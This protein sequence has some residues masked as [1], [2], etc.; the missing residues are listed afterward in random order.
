MKQ[1]I[2]IIFSFLFI[3]AD[4]E[5]VAAKNPAVER[6]ADFLQNIFML[7]NVDSLKAC[8]DTVKNDEAKLRLMAR[9]YFTT[10]ETHTPTFLAELRSLNSKG[11]LIDEGAINHYDN[12]VQFAHRNQFREAIAELKLV[13]DWFDKQMSISTVSD[14][15][16]EIRTIYNAAGLREERL[17]FYQQKLDYYLRNG[18]QENT[19]T[20]YHGIAGYYTLT[21]AY[22][23]AISNYMKAAEVAKKF[24]LIFYYN[25]IFCIGSYYYQ[26]GNK[27]LAR[28]Y[29][30]QVLSAPDKF[31]KGNRALVYYD[32]SEIS[33]EDGK[34]E[35]SINQLDSAEA[36]LFT[37]ETG[38]IGLLFVKEMIRL[39]KGM[40]FL[41]LD[42]DSVAKTYID[43][44]K[45][46]ADS[47]GLRLFTVNGYL[48]TDFALFSYF[49]KSGEKK[50][51]EYFLLNALSRAREQKVNALTLKYLRAAAEFYQTPGSGISSKYYDQYARLTDSLYE[52]EHGNNIAYYEAVLQQNTQNQR[53]D[54]LE[55]LRMI[56]EVKLGQ[57][58]KFLAAGSLALGLLFLLSVTLFLGYR[59]KTKANRTIELERQKSETLLLNILPAEVAEELKAKGNATA[60]QF[61]HVT[62]LFTDFVDFTKAGEKMSPQELVGELDNCFKAF[63]DIIGRYNIEKIKTIGDAYLAVCGL[64]VADPRHAKNVVSAAL[65]I[66]EFMNIRKQELGLNT[67]DI[68]VGIHS[69]PVVA[70]IV[71]VKKFAYDIWGDTV[72]TAARMEQNS[73]AGKIN[74]SETTF[75]LIKDDFRCSYR[76]EID[77]KNKGDMKMFFVE[78][79]QTAETVS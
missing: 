4:C 69:G 30:K 53:I 42:K 78:A 38:D 14:P 45:H 11:N 72:N 65:E 67:F 59:S 35:L 9:L 71:G 19:A 49:R 2:I 58:N 76:G 75:E 41:H 17:A 39:Q 37:N 20:C 68:R 33:W 79:L 62:V 48:E 23:E 32:L 55:D 57:R 47:V 73:E 43:E 70:G 22:N 77:A 28:K 29:L 44:V 61:D 64:P 40:N 12:Y 50:K 63:D 52:A 56:Q 5:Q 16:S 8:L 46:V 54:S 36:S 51:A 26:W 7:N 60:K 74:I 25:E 15:L 10:S 66:R 27:N 21:G 3:V 31:T 34:H 18:P 1:A 13:I 24:S 6:K